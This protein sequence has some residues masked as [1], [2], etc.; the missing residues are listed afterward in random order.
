M[1]YIFNRAFFISELTIGAAEFLAGVATLVKV[2]RGSRGCFAISIPLCTA[3]SGIMSVT[4]VL[5][6]AYFKT[7]CFQFYTFK[8]QKYGYLCNALEQLSM[9]HYWLFAV[10]YLESGIDCSGLLA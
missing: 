9:L 10:K 2:L 1:W 5:V 7:A 3:W 4:V 8:F 6:D